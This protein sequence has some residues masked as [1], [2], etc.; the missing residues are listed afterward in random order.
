ML[1]IHAAQ[2]GDAGVCGE[3]SGKIAE[4]RKRDRILRQIALILHEQARREDATSFAR[5]ISDARLR[6]E[7]IGALALPSGT[8]PEIARRDRPANPGGSA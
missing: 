8:V 3:A 5:T 4:T 1:A 6:D 7:V 2:D